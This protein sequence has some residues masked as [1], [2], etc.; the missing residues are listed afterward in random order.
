MRESADAYLRTNHDSMVPGFGQPVQLVLVER[1]EIPEQVPHPSMIDNR[2][3]PKERAVHSLHTLCR[4]FTGPS[5]P[6]NGSPRYQTQQKR[7]IRGEREAGYRQTTTGAG[8]TSDDPMIARR[9]RIQSAGGVRYDSKGWN[10]RTK[11]PCR[12]H[13]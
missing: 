4:T 1:H 7:W 8:R 11:I 5:A 10:G 2:V 6:R 9:K 3:R 12:A 13:Q